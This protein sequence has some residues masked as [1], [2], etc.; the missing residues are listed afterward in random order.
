VCVRDRLSPSLG[1]LFFFF[2][3]FSRFGILFSFSF[4]NSSGH[5]RLCL[6]WTGM[7]EL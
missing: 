6:V 5:V 7:V 3:F 2:P 1:F 4:L